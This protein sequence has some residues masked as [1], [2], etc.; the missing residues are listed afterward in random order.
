MSE[1][2]LIKREGKM[3]K[4]IR[5]SLIAS[6]VAVAG[7]AGFAGEAKAQSVPVDFNGTVGNVCS[8]TKNQDGTLA[9]RDVSPNTLTAKSYEVATAIMGEISVNCNESGTVTDSGLTPVSAD[10]TTFSQRPNYR[11]GIELHTNFTQESLLPVGPTNFNGTEQTIYVQAFAVDDS[12][13]AV[14]SGTYA[15]TT[16]ITVTPQ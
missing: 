15:F 6:V 4:L 1:E 9:V 14:P 12:G 3:K 16:T 11:G 13:D 8:I 10:A 2:Y 5:N 7:A